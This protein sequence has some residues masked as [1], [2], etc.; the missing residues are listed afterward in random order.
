MILK[1]NKPYLWLPADENADEVKLQFYTEEKKIQE[2][3]IRLGNSVCDFYACW[4]VSEFLGQEIKIEGAGEK[5]LQGIFCWDQPYQNGY[6]YRPKIHFCPPA[7]WHNDP[8]GMV[9]ADGTYHLYYQW[10]PYGTV[11]G[12]M[13]W[14]HARSKDLCHWEDRGKALVPDE[15]GT[16]YSGCAIVDSENELGYGNDAILYYYTSAGGRNKWSQD[17]GNLFTQRL[18]YSVDGGDTLHDSDKFFMPNVIYENRDP[19]IFFHKESGAYIMALYLDGNDFAIYR[20]ENLKDWQETQRLHIPGMWECPDLF[21]LPVRNSQGEKKWVF[22][23]ADGYYLTGEFDGFTF[24]AESKRKSAYRSDIPYAAQTF[25][26][27]GDKVISMS[28]LRLKSTKG[29]YRGQMSLPLELYLL[30]E[31]DEYVIGLEPAAELKNS[32]TESV[33]LS[34]DRILPE[35]RAA[36]IVMTPDEDADGE[37]SLHLGNLRICVDMQGK[38]IRVVDF[39]AHAYYMNVDMPSAGEREITI[40]IDQETVE[41]FT[42]NGKIYGVAETEENILGMTWEIHKSEEFKETCQICYYR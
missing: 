12:N 26:G 18:A 10:N 11:W 16:A 28:W 23:S 24:R 40:I 33:A 5:L 35:G 32:E 41:I 8:N 29:N 36:K 39:D 1:I 15:K 27:T 31:N 20:S 7:G 30:R 13:Q 22:W 4:E 14:G 17:A 42:G 6:A 2:I 38:N 21:Q 19:K 9:Y 3:D 37:W 34:G 25:S